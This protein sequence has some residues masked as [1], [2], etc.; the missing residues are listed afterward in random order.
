M[1]D[2]A[3][4]AP[5]LRSFSGAFPLV[6][7]LLWSLTA[8]VSAAT[9]TSNWMVNT[10]A[11]VEWSRGSVDGDK[12]TALL[13][14]PAGLVTDA[15]GN[16][17]LADLINHNIRKITSAGVVSTLAGSTRGAANGNGSAAQFSYPEKIGIDGGGNL[18]VSETQVS[19]NKVLSWQI[20]KVTSAGAVTV[21]VSNL[22]GHVDSL[23]VY[24]AFKNSLAMTINGIL[25]TVS[26]SGG[27]LQ[28]TQ[29]QASNVAANSSGVLF[30]ERSANIY[31][32]N[33]QI[34]DSVASF[35]ASQESA[36]SFAVD[37]QGAFYC[38]I[39]GV[40]I[41]RLNSLG[42]NG[43]WIV[44]GDSASW[45][46]RD[47]AGGITISPKGIVY[48]SNMGWSPFSSTQDYQDS[49][50]SGW[51]NEIGNAVVRSVVPVTVT[52]QPQGQTVASAASLSKL[53]V[54][55]V[56]D[57]L[58][59]KW[60]KAGLLVSGE[61]SASYTPKTAGIYNAEIVFGSGTDSASVFSEPI[62]VRV[63]T[64]AIQAIR[65]NIAAASASNWSSVL[66]A[67]KTQADGLASSNPE[68]AV[69]S[70]MGSLTSLL[71]D[72]LTKDAA[73]KLGFVGDL[74]PLNLTMTWSGAIPKG[75]KSADI[76]S[77]L[78]T[79]FIPQIKDADAKLALVKDPTFFM[80]MLDVPGPSGLLE[81]S[82]EVRIDYADVQLA[83]AFLKL[84]LVVA[85]L[86]E[87]LN[88]DFSW[89]EV[90]SDFNLGRLSI[91]SL[92]KRYPQLMAA[93][94]TGSTAVADLQTAAK[95]GVTAFFGWSDFLR[96]TV[97]TS[98]KRI[99]ATSDGYLFSADGSD[100]SDADNN[101]RATMRLVRD[102][103]AASTAAAG[104]KTFD[105]SNA[106]FGAISLKA[107]ASHA[108]GWR[109]ELNGMS[110]EK[111]RLKSGGLASASPAGKTIL[112]IFPNA[113]AA[114][115]SE[116][117]S[118]IMGLEQKLN[119]KW[120]TRADTEAPVVKM[121]AL[122][123]L[124]GSKKV[125]GGSGYVT[126][127]GTVTDMS[128]VS[129]V[130]VTQRATGYADN[131]VEAVLTEAPNSTAGAR[132]YTWTAEV[133]IVAGSNTFAVVGTDKYKAVTEVAVT[134]SADVAM[135]Y[136]V[137]V[138]KDGS[139]SVTGAPSAGGVEGG[140]TV[141]LTAAPAA[142]WL[143]RRFEWWM[144]GEEQPAVTTP[145]FSGK[146]NADARIVAVFEKDP[147]RSIPATGVT[148]TRKLPSPSFYN[149]GSAMSETGP[150][151]AVVVTVTKTG[152]IS[153]RLRFGRESLPFTG[154]LGTNG[155]CE[156]SFPRWTG[157][158]SN[159]FSSERSLAFFIQEGDLAPSLNVAVGWWSL[160]TSGTGDDRPGVV[161]KMGALAPVNLGRGARFNWVSD[162][163]SGANYVSL[164]VGSS[165]VVTA[166]GVVGNGERFTASGRIQSA[167]PSTDMTSLS[168][169]ELASVTMISATSDKTT[170]LVTWARFSGATTAGA[171]KMNLN[172]EG[173]HWS[174]NNREP[175]VSSVNGMNSYGFSSGMDSATSI[176]EYQAPKSGELDPFGG[177]G[178]SAKFSAVGSD[179]GD[180]P[181]GWI[182][183]DGSRLAVDSEQ[184]QSGASSYPSMVSTGAGL[185]RFNL[186]ASTGY[187]SGTVG[188]KV[189]GTSTGVKTF[190]GVLIQSNSNN[191]GSYWGVGR[192]TDGTE[193]RI[194]P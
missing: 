129:S 121:N 102:S 91:Q 7:A 31:K 174:A 114:D 155:L 88:T 90:M 153:G 72:P 87:S 189:D 6:V 11:G 184:I 150:V 164:G 152:A 17:Y 146:V 60:Y 34:L 52:A 144:G 36:R 101:L 138:D 74:N 77:W 106:S 142:G 1:K 27:T 46:W 165:G 103:L 67:A 151:S 194:Q 47:F 98:N 177:A 169:D 96:G 8:F 104:V 65:S 84:G 95:D 49:V 82:S 117:E 69:I 43:G 35:P 190:N 135:T 21:L 15:A 28:S 3:F 125:G 105:K 83:R 168:G 24:G 192:T 171:L 130:S 81:M 45:S 61:T 70:A 160:A 134:Q 176:G 30:V 145:T 2:P 51:L 148:L 170:T 175:V 73:A 54:T 131:V 110:F 56:G 4:L 181:V 109:T 23:A 79:K 14:A 55:A 172:Y 37:V 139:G 173:A 13:S 99:P 94:A 40:G 124:T 80:P 149:R 29:L 12:S 107:F 59:Y 157:K 25:Y 182:K 140:T 68:A 178:T 112:S 115:F 18:Y 126:L 53:Q 136:A 143:F 185:L 71:S 132:S 116:F 85:K 100:L 38:G 44:G 166:V 133:P 180:L 5:L 141:S 66:S 111:N 57:G 186:N 22:P 191:G 89:D 120:R 163:P 42:T 156:V 64:P 162:G 33:G 39:P 161:V 16:V 48:F 123:T 32:L 20:R 19:S 10:L 118:G 108:A 122:A 50:N 92:L 78:L 128:E 9:P 187:F 26:T 75:F 113:K 183:W 76:R 158:V 119:E 62:P 193:L 86:V 179:N 159:S 167:L 63:T 188:W 93:S 154:A 147:F 41:Y 137:D 58:S 97:A 127:S